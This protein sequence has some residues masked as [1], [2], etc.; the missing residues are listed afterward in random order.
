MV[1]HGESLM[2]AILDCPRESVH[3]EIYAEWLEQVAAR[4]GDRIAMAHVEFIRLGCALAAGGHDN[5]SR[6]R[7]ERKH[8]EL[9]QS[10]GPRWAGKLV[11]QTASWSFARGFV[12]SIDIRLE[13]YLKLAESIHSAHPVEHLKLLME[14]PGTIAVWRTLATIQ[15][16]A[17]VRDLDISNTGLGS[18]GLEALAA[19]PRLSNLER[20]NVSG[21]GIG[22][23]GVRALL[24]A[25]F[26]SGIR[27]L[28]L[29]HNDIGPGTLRAI[30]E[31]LTSITDSGEVVQLENINL[32]GNPL[33]R[34]GA[35]VIR[36]CRAFHDIVQW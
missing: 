28:N 20:L 9:Q 19:S 32:H 21:N 31:H 24:N 2:Q 16:T 14:G 11:E 34:A 30:S 12:H 27:W 35:N 22:E 23:K 18:N 4:T 26:F 5:L 25:G 8:R 36:A 7:M 15:H 6:M 29:G 1:P 17:H 3:R 33:T 13:E 10:Y